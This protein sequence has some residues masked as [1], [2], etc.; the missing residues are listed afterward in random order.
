MNSFVSIIDFVS[1]PEVFFHLGF[2]NIYSESNHF[3][4]VVVAVVVVVVV[5]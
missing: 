2:A 3:V 1:P 5:V 4:A